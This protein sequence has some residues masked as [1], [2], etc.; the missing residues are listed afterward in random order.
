M[1]ATEKKKRLKT[2]LYQQQ[3]GKCCYCESDMLLSFENHIGQQ[4][5]NLATFEHVYHLWEPD[6]HKK[7]NKDKVM[8]ACYQCN[9][10]KGIEF[11]RRTPLEIRRKMAVRLDTEQFH[12]LITQRQEICAGRYSEI[13]RNDN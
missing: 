13:G 8:L 7:G 5:N 4:P 1:K 3:N 12:E 9:H 10:K 6:R 11:V 2:L